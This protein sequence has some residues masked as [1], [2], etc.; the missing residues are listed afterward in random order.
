MAATINGKMRSTEMASCPGPC[1]SNVQKR[2][3]CLPERRR[4]VHSWPGVCW[5]LRDD[6]EPGGVSTEALCGSH[7]LGVWLVKF[8]RHSQADRRREPPVPGAHMFLLH[9]IEPHALD[10]R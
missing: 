9:S 10:K 8:T 6:G 7:D 5:G 4:G 3:C 1:L 2:L